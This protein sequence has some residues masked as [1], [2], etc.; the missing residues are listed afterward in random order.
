MLPELNVQGKTQEQSKEDMK[1]MISFLIGA[2][3][4]KNIEITNKEG[5]IYVAVEARLMD[6]IIEI[7]T[8]EGI[9]SISYDNILKIKDIKKDVIIFEEIE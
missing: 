8:N 9:Q 7:K 2:D 4:I 1:Y 6:E 3:Y 5:D